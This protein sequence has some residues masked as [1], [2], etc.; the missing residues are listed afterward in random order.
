M[1]SNVSLP[2]SQ[3]STTGPLPEPLESI[4]RPLS[5]DAFQ[6]YKGVD[7]ACSK[8]TTSP[9]VQLSVL[10][11]EVFLTLI[12]HRDVFWPTDFALSSHIYF[13][14]L[15]IRVTRV[16]HI[17]LQD[18]RV[19]VFVPNSQIWYCWWQGGEGHQDGTVLTGMILIPSY[20]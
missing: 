6:G 14:I 3:D 15:P 18:D 1:E 11:A 4:L 9:L 2:C 5:V 7:H 8:I 16:C 12:T 20:M 13:S 17:K 10:P 19:K